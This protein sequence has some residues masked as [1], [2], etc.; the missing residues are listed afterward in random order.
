MLILNKFIR[1]QARFETTRTAFALSNV[2]RFNSAESREQYCSRESVLAIANVCGEGVSLLSQTAASRV[3]IRLSASVP[4]AGMR[5]HGY[6]QGGAATILAVLAAPVFGNGGAWSKKAHTY[7]HIQLKCFALCCRRG[8]AIASTS[9]M[10]PEKA[11]TKLF[12]HIL[13]RGERGE[14]FKSED[15]CTHPAIPRGERASR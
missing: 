1:L 15:Q 10:L 2:S 3:S 6:F 14:R 7:W 11:P 5:E 9:N 12:W 8:M 4:L 13:K